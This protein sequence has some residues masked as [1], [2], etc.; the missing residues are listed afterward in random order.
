MCIHIAC[1]WN[2]SCRD[3]I[4][5]YYFDFDCNVA[6]CC[7]FFSLFTPADNKLCYGRLCAALRVKYVVVRAAS[8]MSSKRQRARVELFF[9]AAFQCSMQV[10]VR[11]CFVNLFSIDA[12]RYILN[13]SRCNS[14]FLLLFY[15]AIDCLNL[16]PYL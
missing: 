4:L 5:I 16:S 8:F 10:C 3:S 11:H 15:H 12:N 1:S 7:V 14:F 6:R 9:N 2:G 13:F